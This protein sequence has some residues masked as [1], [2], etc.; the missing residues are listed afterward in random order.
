LLIFFYAVVVAVLYR[1]GELRSLLHVAHLAGILLMLGIFA[2]WAIPCLQMM[3]D[4]GVA[5]TWSRQ[6]SGRLSGEDFKLSGWLMNIPRGLCYFLPWTPLLAF[7]NTAR[8][9]DERRAALAKGLIRGI[10]ISFLAVSLLPGS[11]ARYTMPL[12]PAAAWLLA[13]LLTADSF[14]LPQWLRLRQPTALQPELRLPAVVTVLVC[15]AIAFYAF[16]AMPQLKRREKIRTIAAQINAVLPAGEPLYAI[17]PDYQ[18]FLFYV[19]DPI[20]YVDRVADAPLAARFLLVQKGR[21]EQAISSK[22]WEP[23]RA[24]PILALKDYRNKEVMVLKLGDG[25]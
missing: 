23:L 17:D 5:Q 6:F 14:A 21:E 8:F 13:M 1:A 25:T 20:V 16:A 3:H 22:K 11:L 19:R 12:L 15:A 9:G 4:S 24:R 7:A 18:P 10:T 2:A